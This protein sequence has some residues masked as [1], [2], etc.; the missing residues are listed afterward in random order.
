MKTEKTTTGAETA[1]IMR[2]VEKR[3]EIDEANT[4]VASCLEAVAKA[5]ADQASK[6]RTAGLKGETAYVLGLAEDAAKAKRRVETVV[7]E[8]SGM[9]AIAT[10]V[11]IKL[12]GEAFRA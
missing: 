8:W 12:P 5:A 4:K 6:I 7:A 10:L 3:N 9:I 1:A 11:G 2:I